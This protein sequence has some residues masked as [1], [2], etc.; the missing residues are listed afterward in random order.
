MN[1]T[2]PQPVTYQQVTSAWVNLQATAPRYHVQVYGIGD[3]DD[4]VER[5]VQGKL[6]ERVDCEECYS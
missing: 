2:N 3:S 1:K 5:H 6:C 4:D